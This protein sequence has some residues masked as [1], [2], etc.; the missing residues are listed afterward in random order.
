MLLQDILLDDLN[1]S[2]QHTGNGNG[3]G[4]AGS[5]WRDVA[6]KAPTHVVGVVRCPPSVE[7]CSPCLLA[8]AASMLCCCECLACVLAGALAL[9]NAGLLSY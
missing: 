1:Q 8:S 4:M 5:G 3:N 7:V 6:K 9:D 2:S